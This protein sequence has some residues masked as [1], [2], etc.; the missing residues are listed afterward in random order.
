MAVAARSRSLHFQLGPFDGGLNLRDSYTEIGANEL[1]DGTNFTLDERGMATKRNDCP[2]TAALAGASTPPG[3]VLVFFYSLALNLFICQVGSTLYKAAPGAASW[4]SFRTLGSSAIVNFVDFAAKLVYVHPLDGVRTYDGTTDAVATTV[5]VGPVEGMPIAVWQNK[6]WVVG[7]AGP[8]LAAAQFYRLYWSNAGAPNTWT[9]AS[10][11]IDL[12]E[13]DG[14]RITALFGGSGLLA[15]KDD[16]SYRINDST[17]GS[18]QTIDSTTGCVGPLAVVGSEGRVYTWGLDGLYEGDGIGR[19]RNVGDKLRPRFLST[20]VNATTKPLISAV[21]LNG[22]VYFAFPRTSSTIP[23]AILEL[24]PRTGALMEQYFNARVGPFAHYLNASGV[25]TASFASASATIKD[26]FTGTTRTGFSCSLATGYVQPFGGAAGRVQRFRPTLTPPAAS[27]LVI[28][29][30]YS[31]NGGAAQTYSATVTF[32]NAGEQSE[33]LWPRKI[34]REVQVTLNDTASPLT[35]L[36][37]RSALLDVDL[38]E[39]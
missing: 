33:D 27:S 17:T 25:P 32:A 13:K 31:D 8:D 21:A 10:D 28:A 20:N 5:P 22:R 1:A 26:L 3:S 23:D 9:T 39:L 24:N 14:K 38:A 12:R 15:F 30:A 36:A 11:F 19:F 6:C 7:S 37:V 35:S 34:V 16:S 2:T 4:T 29:L 18:Y